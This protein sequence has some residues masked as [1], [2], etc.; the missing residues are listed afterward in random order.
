MPSIFWIGCGVA[1]LVAVISAMYRRPLEHR[2]V[3]VRCRDG[4]VHRLHD[5]LPADRHRPRLQLARWPTSRTSGSATASRSRSSASASSRCRR[6]TP[7][8][9]S[10]TAARDRLPPHRHRRR[11]RQRAGVGAGI[12]A[13]GVPRDEIFVTTK[14]WNADQGYDTTLRR[15]RAHGS[16]RLGIDHVDL[17]LIHWPV[18]VPGTATSTPG[19]RSSGCSGG[20]RRARSASPTSASSTSNGCIGETGVVPTVNQI[21][22]H[23]LLQQAELRA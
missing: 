15:L 18:A 5:R 16:K 4:P 13:S 7:S 14:L 11:L 8:A 3:R 19:G 21:E 10:R 6:R 22:L 23:P 17:Y 9:R 20:P 12:A 2:D 1:A